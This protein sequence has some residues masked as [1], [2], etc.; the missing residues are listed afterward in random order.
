VVVF[1]VLCF[2]F[3]LC[4][5]GQLATDEEKAGQAFFLL[6]FARR[7]PSWEARMTSCLYDFML[8]SFSFAVSMSMIAALPA[9]TCSFGFKTENAIMA[10]PIRYLS[11]ISNTMIWDFRAE[12]LME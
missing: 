8:A 2:F 7:A 6:T 12:C 9:S 11:P 10:M 3:A 5:F 4:Y 1:D